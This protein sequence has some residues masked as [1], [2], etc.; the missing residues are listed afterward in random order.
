LE[1]TSTRLISVDEA[2]KRIAVSRY[3][4]R[5]WLRQGRLPFHRLGR[6]ILLAP[7]D[8]ENFIAGNRVEARSMTMVAA[9][10][11]ILNVP[12]S[13]PANFTPAQR[14]EVRRQ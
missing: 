13:R 12:S 1:N 4:L 11:T 10:R 7:I 9:P 3:T 2:A 5:S 6:R 8:L 14:K